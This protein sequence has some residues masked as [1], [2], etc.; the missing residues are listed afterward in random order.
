MWGGKAITREQDF[1]GRGSWQILSNKPGVS[2]YTASKTAQLNDGKTRSVLREYK[3]TAV[4]LHQTAQQVVGYKT[5]SWN[6]K[7]YPNVLTAEPGAEINK[8]KEHGGQV[9]RAFQSHTTACVWVSSLA[10][11]RNSKANGNHRSLLHHI[12]VLQCV[13]Y[14][15]WLL[16]RCRSNA[17]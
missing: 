9:T 4:P 15:N 14:R 11:G 1:G 6:T 12:S 17:L 16:F 7:P 13:Q 3:F 8:D 2:L 10:E 5:K